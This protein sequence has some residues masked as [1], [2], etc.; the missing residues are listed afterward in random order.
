M[1]KYKEKDD[2]NFINFVWIHAEE[3]PKKKLN[4]LVSLGLNSLIYLYFPGTFHSGSTGMY[5][6][7][8]GSIKFSLSAKYTIK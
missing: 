6:I 2:I 3:I 1:K 7:E 4:T 8:N 5:I